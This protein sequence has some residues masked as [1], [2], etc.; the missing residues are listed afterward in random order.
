MQRKAHATRRIENAQNY[1]VKEQMQFLNLSDWLVALLTTR[2]QPG[3][4]LTS[5]P[6]YSRD[7]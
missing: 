4:H 5:E 2:L 7:T 3:H 6:T 1:V